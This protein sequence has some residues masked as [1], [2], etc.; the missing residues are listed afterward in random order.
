M[1]VMSRRQTLIETILVF[2]VFFLQGDWPVPDVN[3][4]YY[5]GKAIHFWNPAWAPSDIFLQ[6]ADSH[7]VFYWTVGWLSL[8]LSPTAMAWTLRTITWA[9]LAWAWRRLSVAV[10]PRPWFS[11]LTATLFVFLMQ[12]FAMAGEWVVGGA[13]AKG[14]AYV[15]V[16]LAVEAMLRGRWNRT[17]L[18]LGGASAFHVLVGG[19][20]AVA[21]GAAR[22]SQRVSFWER[23]TKL[24]SVPG[25]PAKRPQVPS[26]RRMAA[27]LAAGGLLALAGLIPALG[28]DRH[29]DSAEIRQAH[30]IYVFQ[31]LP[32][33]LD[34]FQFPADHV[35]GFL[36][37]VAV[38]LG[39]AIRVSRTRPCEA[40]SGEPPCGLLMVFVNATLVMALAGLGLRI[41]GVYDGGLAAGL[42]RFYW[43][44]LADVAVPLGVAL[45]GV[46]QVVATRLPASRCRRCC[47]AGLVLLAVFHEADCRV[48]RLFAAPPFDERLP[49]PAAWE[50]AFEWAAGHRE[51][52]SFPR[53]PR[54]DRLGDFPAWQDACTWVAESGQIPPAARF[55]TPLASQTFKWYAGRGEVATLKDIPQDAASML[56]W[57][58]S[59]EDIHGT[60][61]EPPLPRWHDS[62]ADLGAQRL[63]ELGAKYRAQFALTEVTEPPLPL[64]VVYKNR[65]YV[66]YRLQ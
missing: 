37:L 1:V 42:L 40:A 9:L 20:A 11:L 48:L 55:L 66:I 44:R 59:L 4:P 53:Q 15:L 25:P 51:L 43:F 57:W 38:W 32:H 64:P 7:W 31:R 41:L 33:H 49:D 18:L 61:N 34:C 29:V 19:W 6:T 21:A 46:R 14:F 62:L 5:L 27:A 56:R 52:P 26:L 3:E 60:G 22:L 39:L 17:W 36:L 47:L 13:E 24:R 45:V 28:L 12:H 23:P 2:A 16:L 63:R 35:V 50:S 58:Q 30:E 10:V 8:V 65:T 54:A